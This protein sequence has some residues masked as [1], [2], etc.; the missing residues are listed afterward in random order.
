[1]SELRIRNWD[2]WQNYRKDRGQPPWIKI[3]REVMRN[4]EWVSLSDAQRGQLV[5]IWLLAADRGG[6]IPASPEV[7]RKLC[8][9][10]N[11][12]DLNL[13]IEKG[14]IDPPSTGCQVVVNVTPDRRQ[15]DAPETETETETEADITADAVPSKYVFEAGII[16]LTQKSFDQWKL[17]FRHLDLEAEL[18]SLQ[19]WAGDQGGNWFHA[20]AAALNKKNGK[21]KAAKEAPQL[22]ANRSY[23]GNRK[24]PGI[25]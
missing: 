12:P 23:W 24:I 6:V 17:A 19:K 2:K 15:H 4:P 5:A 1:M 9:L 22:D 21:I 3:H 16:R 25:Q 7:I 8:Y 13:L 18:I 11:D 10:D 20:V 14:F